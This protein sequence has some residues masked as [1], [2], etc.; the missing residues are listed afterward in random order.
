MSP[1]SL[2]WPHGMHIAHAQPFYPTLLSDGN[3]QLGGSVVVS[4]LHNRQKVISTQKAINSGCC[5]DDMA[6]LYWV[7]CTGV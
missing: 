2:A 5:E 1:E 7:I 6:V 3:L 4:A